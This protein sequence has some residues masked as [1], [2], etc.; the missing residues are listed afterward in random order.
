[1][2]EIH[3]F[4]KRIISDEC[5]VLFDYKPDENWQKYFNV[6]RGEWKYEDGWLVGK[7][8]GN[9]GGIMLTKE[10]YD[11]NVMFS[12]TGATV[13]PATRDLNAL[14]NARI[15]EKNNYLG[16]SYVC[17]LNGWYEHKSGIEKNDPS[18]NPYN[19]LH[20]STTSYQYVPGEEVR[21]TCGSVDGHC[22]MLVNGQLVTEL[23]DLDPLLGGY[24]GFSPYCT[25]MKVKD[26]E[27][28]KI[29]WETFEQTYDPEF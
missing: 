22:F 24:V 15:D 5:P 11:C 9:F 6:I 20:A 13:L 18:L 21:M 17:G 4:G 3:L 19:L 1:M 8:N 27:I 23:H 26:F 16:L 14:F 7:E 25:I 28:R 29:V 2:N 12:F 10:W